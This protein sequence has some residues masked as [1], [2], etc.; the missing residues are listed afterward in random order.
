[1]SEEKSAYAKGYSAGRKKR[2][3]QEVAAQV[4]NER[5]TKL[6]AA[7]ISA[8]MPGEWGVTVNGKHKKHTLE[9]LESMAVKSAR[10]MCGQMEVIE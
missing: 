9:Q 5:F 4:N 7:I 2:R 8:A 10:R 1:M 6:A 3:R